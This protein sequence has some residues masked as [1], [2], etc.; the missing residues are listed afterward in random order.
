M[1]EERSGC[2]QKKMREVVIEENV[3]RYVAL[4]PESVVQGVFCRVPTVRVPCYS[5]MIICLSF[6]LYPNQLQE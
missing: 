2:L 6:P 3:A 5:C 1:L 4:F